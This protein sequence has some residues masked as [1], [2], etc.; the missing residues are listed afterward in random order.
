VSL[1]L[2]VSFD[3]GQRLLEP[4]LNQALEALEELAGVGIDA[5]VAHGMPS[6]LESLPSD[7]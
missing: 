3:G 5:L 6:V 2:G 4:S 7:A 1:T